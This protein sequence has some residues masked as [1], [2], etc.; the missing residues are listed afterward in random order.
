MFNAAIIKTICSSHSGSI[1]ALNEPV[2]PLTTSGIDKAREIFRAAILQKDV[3]LN[4][5]DT[6]CVVDQ[7]M[8][9]ELLLAGGLISQIIDKE[10]IIDV[11]YRFYKGP[12]NLE[13]DDYLA[14]L[15]TFQAPAY[16][17]GQRLRRNA[18]RGELKDMSDLIIRGCDVN[19]ADG[20]GLTSLHYAC[21][22]NRPK[23]LATLE[24]LA[25]NELMINAKVPE[26]VD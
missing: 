10:S 2:L 19:T 15:Q 14:F 21:E 25:S 4:N 16:Y 1:L 23:I 13:E 6:K 12:S 7:S 26:C 22:F 3:L 24:A 8:I 11:I 5:N 20:E 9:Y 18:G 17:Y